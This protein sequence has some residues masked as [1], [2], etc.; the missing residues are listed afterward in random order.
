MRNVDVL[1]KLVNIL[2]ILDGL[3]LQ[4]AMSNSTHRFDE[5]GQT[6]IFPVGA[7]IGSRVTEKMLGMSNLLHSAK[8]YLQLSDVKHGD[9]V[10][11]LN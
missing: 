6:Y 7:T 1:N 9:V 8:A 10:T 5:N 4:I 3:L 2:P 11:R